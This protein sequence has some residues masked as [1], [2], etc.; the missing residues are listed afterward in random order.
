[1][2]DPVVRKGL[3]RQRVAASTAAE[4]ARLGVPRLADL[5]AELGTDYELSVDVKDPAAWAPML[6][7]ARA[8]GANERLWMC[9]E[10]VDAL[11]EVR[12]KASD[13]RV[14]HSGRRRAISVPLERHAH[15]LANIGVDAMNLHHSDWSGGLVSLFHRFDLKAFAWDAQEVRHLRA[16]LRIG[17]DGLYCDRPDRMVAVVSEWT[18]E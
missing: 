12:P 8:A 17:V 10:H 3:R 13:V 18:D 4:L 16:M 11:R 15:D 5:Y 14:V 2:H 9:F 6:D 1:V 7:V